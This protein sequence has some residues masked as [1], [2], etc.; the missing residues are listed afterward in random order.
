MAEG[1]RGLSKTENFFGVTDPTADPEFARVQKLTDTML[2]REKWR[3]AILINS[4][5]H[6][7]VHHSALQLK[8]GGLLYCIG[9]MNQR[10]QL[11]SARICLPAENYAKL[12]T[13]LSN[14]LKDLWKATFIRWN[15]EELLR[16]AARRYRAFLELN[17]EKF[18]R[19]TMEFD[20]RSRQ[21]L[22]HFWNTILPPPYSE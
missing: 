21:G 2:K 11:V 19:K 6:Y 12:V 9:K 14:P 4:M 17:D 8:V 7:D 18:Y 22:W 10:H 16:V 3:I 1:N 20:I 15:A 5:E 13:H